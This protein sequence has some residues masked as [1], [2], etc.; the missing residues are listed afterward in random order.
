MP[1][2]SKTCSAGIKFL[3][4]ALPDEIFYRGFCFLNHSFIPL[5]CAKCSDSL[6]FSGAS[7]IL[8]YRILFPTIL[9]HQ[10]CFHPPSLRPAIWFLVYL[11]VFLL[12]NSYSILFWGFSFLPF[13]VRV[14]TNVIYGTLL[15]LLLWVF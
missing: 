10:L 1:L 11:L 9:L 3:R 13:S 15:S 2:P 12:P 7:S 5:V 6:P 4:A 8:P 14:Q